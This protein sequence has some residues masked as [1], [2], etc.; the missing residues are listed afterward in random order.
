MYFANIYVT[1]GLALSVIVGVILAFLRWRNST[2]RE[3]RMKR[4]MVSCGLDEETIAKADQFLR[5]D[6][7]AARDRCR[8]CPV[9]Y[10]C[11]RWLDGEAVANNSFCPNAWIFSRTAGSGQ[12]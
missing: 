1:V 2:A 7:D 12:P 11:D 9:T 6:I 5:F 3:S 10:L 4:M 8:H